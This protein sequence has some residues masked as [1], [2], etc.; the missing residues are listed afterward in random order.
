MFTKSKREKSPIHVAINSIPVSLKTLCFCHFNIMPKRNKIAIKFNLNIRSCSGR[1][2]FIRIAK[3]ALWRFFK[4]S[5]LQKRDF[6]MANVNTFA[7][8]HFFNLKNSWFA[9]HSLLTN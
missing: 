2:F 6:I 5:D 9:L 4:I 1:K 7:R 8:L 3:L